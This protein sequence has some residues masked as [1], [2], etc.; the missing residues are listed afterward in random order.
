M[1]AGGVTH[2]SLD[3]VDFTISSTF[4]F[5]LENAPPPFEATFMQTGSGAIS[6]TLT[7]AG[8]TEQDGGSTSG[9]GTIVAVRLGGGSRPPTTPV[10][11]NKEVRF[12]VCAVVLNE[13][14]CSA[15]DGS[16]I[17]GVG[18]TGTLGDAFISHQLQ[19]PCPQGGS[20]CDETPAIYFLEDARQMANAVYR[21]TEGQEL[22]VQLLI[23]GETKQTS[24]G[25]GNVIISKDL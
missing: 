5:V 6:I 10:A 16:S 9:Q 20:P 17:F 12:D 3:G 18:I 1:V 24:S 15:I 22:V 25:T 2:P 11:P 7:V 19:L 4:N 8:Q 13:P 23:N 14:S 21:S